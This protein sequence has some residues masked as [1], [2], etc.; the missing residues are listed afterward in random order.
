MALVRLHVLALKKD[1]PNNQEPK[2][3]EQHVIPP[4]I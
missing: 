1:N 2:E 3:M 4:V